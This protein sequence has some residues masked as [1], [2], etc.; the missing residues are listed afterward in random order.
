[1][2]IKIF[3]V[4]ISICLAYGLI[5]VTLKSTGGD[6]WNEI[7]QAQKPLLLLALL[8]YGGASIT[9]PIYR[10]NLLLKVQGISLRVWELIRL[11]MIGGFFNMVIPGAVSGDLVKMIFLGKQTK[12]KRLEALFTIILDR[13]LGIIGLF[14]LAA[15]MVLF[16]LPFLLD[17]KQG[18][19]SIKV[20]ALFVGIVSICGIIGLPLIKF[21][22]TLKRYFWIDRII[23]YAEQK[24]PKSM[25]S[26]LTRLINAFDLY[27]HN[28]STIVIGIALSIL[29]HSFLAIILFLVGISIGEDVL[30]LGDY[31]LSTQISSAIAIIPITPGGIGIRDATIALFFSALHATPE[32]IGPLPVIMTLIIIFWRLIGGIIFAFYKFPAVRSIAIMN[33]KS[34]A[35]RSVEN[36]KKNKTISF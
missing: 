3:R 10:W 35:L 6:I 11:T 24:L 29:I 4:I 32:K 16:Y 8:F 15:I 23:K 12:E 9:L 28:L 1:M 7:L 22:Q 27:R 21:G 14:I 33:H 26:A 2:V 5:H 30:R 18:Y 31:F 25:V 19:R 13:T 36:T 34:S 17:L 20:A